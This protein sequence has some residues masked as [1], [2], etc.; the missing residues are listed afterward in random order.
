[1]P[2]GWKRGLMVAVAGVG[3]LGVTGCAAIRQEEAQN[4]GNLLAAAGFTVKPA[5][6]PA[7]VEHFKTMPPLKMVSRTKDGNLVYMLA[8]PYSCNCLY[9]GGPKQYQEYRRLA[10]QKQI[11][12]DKLMAAQAEED[13]AMNWGLWGPWWW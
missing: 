10:L 2:S 5:D 7:K 4:T 6:T 11:A 12:E 3:L 1:M 8:D 9:V 13:A